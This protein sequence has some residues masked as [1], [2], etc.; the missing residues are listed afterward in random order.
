VTRKNREAAIFVWRGETVLVMH[1]ARD[2]IWNVPAGQIEDG[3]SFEDG[4]A[5]ELMEE[6]GL[7][8][9]LIDLDMPIWY[10]VEPQ[11]QHLY[12]A[13]EY[14]VLVGSY[15]AVAPAGWEPTLNHEHDDYRWCSLRDAVEL[16]FWPEA[17]QGARAAAARLGLV[18]GGLA[19]S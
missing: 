19:K 12:A 18:D 6:A 1:R 9:D 14:R 4:A 10:E 16:L 2:G 3:E 11:F 7:E 13:G 15:A 8:A 17:R 5:R